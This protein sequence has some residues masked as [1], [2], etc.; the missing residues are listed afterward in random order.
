MTKTIDR[1]KTISGDA[2][3]CVFTVEE[4]GQKVHCP[5]WQLFMPEIA[6]KTADGKPRSESAMQK[7]FD[8]G[9]IAALETVAG[10]PDGVR[11]LI[12]HGINARV[13]DKMNTSDET[14][15]ARVGREDWQRVIAGEATTRSGTGDPTAEMAREL[16][17][18][19][20][21][22]F[23]GL[24]KTAARDAAKD[25]SAKTIAA[26]AAKRGLEAKAYRD[27]LDQRVSVALGLD[28]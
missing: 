15:V 23:L 17:A 10:L 27:K 22:R 26:I 7:D 1:Q 11:F 20:A 8:A 24:N 12:V 16:V 2:V 3:G 18:Q 25:E 5:V 13:G 6:D 14:D 28:D 19:D 4:S 9:K 21:R